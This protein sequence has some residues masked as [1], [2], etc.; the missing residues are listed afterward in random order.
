[1]S[2]HHRLARM[3]ARI[4]ALEARFESLDAALAEEEPG[5]VM[6][7]ASTLDGPAQVHGERDQTQSLG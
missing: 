7:D 2:L 5:P 1:M 4:T 6:V 3:E